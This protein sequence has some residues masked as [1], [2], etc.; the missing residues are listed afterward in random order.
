MWSTFSFG[1]NCKHTLFSALSGGFSLTFAVLILLYVCNLSFLSLLSK[2]KATSVD[3]ISHLGVLSFITQQ[4]E[5]TQ[6]NTHMN[7]VYV[8][9][10]FKEQGP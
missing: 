9:F 4:T 1:Q 8:E 2:C 6:S 7:Y 3:N 10:K 5:L